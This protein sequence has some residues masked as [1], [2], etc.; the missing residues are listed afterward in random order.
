[1]IVFGIHCNF[2]IVLPIQLKTCRS[3]VFS[4]LL[5]FTRR[6]LGTTQFLCQ[7]KKKFLATIFV[8]KT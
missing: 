7:D 6:D 8:M 2:L 3:N 5:L 1:M 4:L